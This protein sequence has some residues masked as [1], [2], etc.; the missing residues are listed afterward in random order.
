MGLSECSRE[1]EIGEECG[2]IFGV[3]FPVESKECL[4]AFDAR[5]EGYRRIMVPPE[6][7]AIDTE[8]GS[9]AAQERAAALKAEVE[10]S[11][12]HGVGR[13]P[14][15]WTY[16]PDN[17]HSAAPD[18]KYPII[19]TYVDVCIRGCLA[20]GGRPLALEFIQSTSGWS[21][22]YL[23]DA[24]L[25]RR[26]WIHRKD[27][28]PVDECLRALSSVC[29]F[30]ER[31]HTEDFSAEHLSPLKGL[32]GVPPRNRYF[33][34][35][36]R[37]LADIM[38]SLQQSGELEESVEERNAAHSRRCM[39]P[40]S[41][42]ASIVGLGGVGKTQTAVEF[43]H[44]QFTEGKFGLVMWL[45]ATTAEDIATD[46]RRFA[47]DSGI[48]RGNSAAGNTNGAPGTDEA[49]YN[50]DF[51][52]EK[53]ADE[54]RRKLVRSRCNWLVV[55][56]NVEDAA[57][58]SQYAH[59]LQPE[60]QSKNGDKTYCGHMLI[61]SRYL[62]PEW[63]KG[64][65]TI[66]LECF[67]A[68][69]SIAYI[70]S[71][72]GMLECTSSSMRSH[73]LGLS[74]NPMGTAQRSV[75]LE[76]AL[77]MGCL[78]LALSMAVA[79]MRSC[80]V[81]VQ[82]YVKR[83]DSIDM[84]TKYLEGSSQSA[85][86][87]PV[88][89]IGVS[90][91][92]AS[93][94]STLTMSLD[95]IRV[96]SQCASNLVPCLGFLYP[97]NIT[98][99]FIGSLISSIHSSAQQ[100]AIA[101]RG[102]RSKLGKSVLLAAKESNSLLSAIRSDA[103]LRKS[104]FHH[105][106]RHN[107]GLSGS[108]FIPLF[109]YSLSRGLS[110]LAMSKWKAV[111]V[112]TVCTQCFCSF[113]FGKLLSQVRLSEL[114]FTFER[115]GIAERLLRPS[116]SSTSKKEMS[117]C[118]WL[119]SWLPIF[120]TSRIL[121]FVAYTRKTGEV[122]GTIAD[123]NEQIS[124]ERDSVWELM[125]QFSIMTVRGTRNEQRIGS[126][127]RL[128]Q[129]VIQAQC[130]RQQMARC[131][132]HCIDACCTSWRFDNR[133]PDFSAWDNCGQLLPHLDVIAQHVTKFMHLTR[134]VRPVR[135]G[136]SLVQK[137]MRAVLSKAE[138]QTRETKQGQGGGNVASKYCCSIA[139]ELIH[140]AV[141]CISFH[142]GG[143]EVEDLGQE[144]M[145]DTSVDT[146]PFGPFSEGG[147]RWRHLL[148]LSH[149]CMQAG[150]YA[151]VVQAKFDSAQSFQ[152]MAI[153]LINYLGWALQNAP[154]CIKRNFPREEG[155]LYIQTSAAILY[156]LGK[157]LR[158]S[159]LF[160]KA[161]EALSLSLEIKQRQSLVSPEISDTLHELG[162]LKL[163]LHRLSEAEVLLTRSRNLKKQLKSIKS[164]KLAAGLS[165]GLASVNEGDTSEASTLHQLGV[166]SRAQ[167]RYE[168]AEELLHKSLDSAAASSASLNSHTS[169]TSRA[170]TVQ[171]LG[172]IALR[173]GHLEQAQALFNEA[174]QLYESAYGDRHSATHINTIAVR[175]QLGNT[176]IADRR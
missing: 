67:N 73:Q 153:D 24:P 141:S 139:K 165:V 1:E 116:Q 107:I 122:I 56:D 146:H 133:N 72:L 81:D 136:G 54:I 3:L 109:S 20:W 9:A 40:G 120:D 27:F 175:H 30:A 5:E 169:L 29:L 71:A 108:L 36:S 111:L 28:I 168:Y 33:V 163:K 87:G 140:S 18:E 92:N 101:P 117:I 143:D 159:G 150:L 31:K 12:N 4:A 55:L 155:Y 99:A 49:E 45:R 161:N 91:V 47:F 2:K 171:Q 13:G 34:G 59:F 39:T 119:L 98:K 129:S 60:Q 8:L 82:E 26:P 115:L 22:F 48:L 97:D 145:A 127:H 78:P 131:L 147:V 6:C 53:I 84:K 21:S 105:F 65:N 126:I 41:H 144:S 152:D 130:S 102:C 64:G 76:L 86:Q 42:Q 25:S 63:E 173:R 154:E 157:T 77:K 170:A 134:H 23:N 50:I 93:I 158:Y 124:A 176:A 10:S 123:S 137:H 95:R 14:R 118:G 104:F 46:L 62:F 43:V 166:V 90:K 110:G 138:F 68:D 58:V 66:V 80:H 113:L 75:Y 79:Y 96:E 51:D 121:P 88:G 16:V 61:T 19:Q 132:E 174:L 83:L 37:V 69:E 57:V 156:H 35:R 7:M 15:F 125:I 142:S 167:R 17:E 94:V 164:L 160:E 149:L 70:H 100:E 89:S 11:I 32:C 162:V 151:S 135:D 38:S 44:Q 148:D 85:A 112:G 74:A 172:R 128:Q 103:G 114:Y 52:D 106:V